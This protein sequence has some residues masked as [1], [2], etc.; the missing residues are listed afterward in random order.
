MKKTTF[1]FVFIIELILLLVLLS[2]GCSPGKQ[3]GVVVLHF[4]E[5]V[6]EDNNLSLRVRELDGKR[7]SLTGFMAI[8][9]PLDGSFVYLT[10]M[11]LVVCPYCIPGTNT[12]I[13]AIPALASPGR[14][15]KYT[16]QPVTVTGVLEVGEKTDLFGYTTPLRINVENIAVADAGKLSPSLKEYAMLASDG[17]V[18]EV[19]VLLDQL[20]A[21]TT[22]DL[23]RFDPAMLYAF[24]LEKI[25]GLIRKVRGYGV[26]SYGGLIDILQRARGLAVEVNQ[27]IESQQQELMINFAEEGM[28]LWRAYFAWADEMAALD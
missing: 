21:Y 27:L 10:N 8:Q 17:V 5:L 19:L 23:S 14:P 25:D 7:V 2:A 13:S 16:E 12:P 9:S 22:H 20:V 3:A 11:P 24:D 1:V 15:I 28:F 6:D 18:I 26:P 4:R